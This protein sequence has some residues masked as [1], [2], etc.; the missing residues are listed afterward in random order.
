MDRR[1][2]RGRAARLLAALV[3]LGAPPAPASGASDYIGDAQCL[4]CHD[5]LRAHY[6]ET[7]HARV[8]GAD[9]GRTELARHGCE[10]CHGPGAGHVAAGGGELAGMLGFRGESP[11]V[12]AENAA[13][14]ACHSRGERLH[15]SGSAHDSRDTAC[16]SCHTL[17]RNVSPRHLL[18]RETE[19]ETCT[20][21]H[22]IQR[23]KLLRNAHMPLREGAMSCSSCHAPHGSANVSL[24]RHDT[25]NDVCTSCHAGKRGPFLWE[26]APVT[27]SCLN[28]HD[29]HGSVRERMLKLSVPRLCQQCHIETR[30]PTEARRPDNRFVIGAACNQCHVNIHGSNHPSGMAFTR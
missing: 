22:L 20:S 2:A 29:P 15:W 27:E 10:A 11:A 13:C 5:D 9:R 4:V 8:L 18:E 30:H 21:C 6:E 3:A 12:D 24:L 26:H 17:M 19:I 23:S 25:V 7:V 1:A 14:L 28:C 16:T